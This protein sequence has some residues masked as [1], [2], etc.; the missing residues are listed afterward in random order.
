MFYSYITGCIVAYY[1][2]YNS[3]VSVIL[4]NHIIYC[5]DYWSYVD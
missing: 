3:S 1:F 5:S 4:N 2:D